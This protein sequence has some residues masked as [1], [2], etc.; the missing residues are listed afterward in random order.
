M[1]VG[2]TW[3]QI[4]SRHL[5]AR[6]LIRFFFCFHSDRSF[7]GSWKWKWL[8]KIRT[9]R[10]L[11]MKSSLLET[12]IEEENQLVKILSDYDLPIRFYKSSFL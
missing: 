6:Q 5:W 3:R 10:G 12:F 9:G 4:G 7:D 8:V 11:V 1:S 2:V